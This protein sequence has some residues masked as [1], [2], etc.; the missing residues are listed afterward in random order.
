MFIM[1]FWGIEQVDDG[2]SEV[3]KMNSSDR[4]IWQKYS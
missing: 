4:E 3:R 1:V 2:R